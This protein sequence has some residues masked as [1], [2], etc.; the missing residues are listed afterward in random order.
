M[1]F[2]PLARNLIPERTCGRIRFRSVL[3][4]VG[5]ALWLGGLLP[6]A[7]ADFQGSTHIMPFDE[8]TIAYSKTPATGPV[9]QLQRK[10]DTGEVTLEFDEKFGY[11]KA[12]LKA[13][14]VPVAGV[15]L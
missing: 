14:K 10:I 2:L 3:I 8:D 11:L 12:L 5:C 13:F 9:T 6:A 1:F 7:R 4:G 15:L